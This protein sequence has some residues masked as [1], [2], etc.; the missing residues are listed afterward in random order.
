MRRPCGFQIAFCVALFLQ[1]LLSSAQYWSQECSLGQTGLPVRTPGPQVPP[2]GGDVEARFPGSRESSR[3]RIGQHK[4]KQLSP[5]LS[6]EHRPCELGTWQK[7]KPP[8]FP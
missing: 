4:E 7:S 5:L 2:D 6:R 8:L 3:M 1:L